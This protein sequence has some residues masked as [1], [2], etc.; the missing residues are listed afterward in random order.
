MNISEK[1]DQ[2]RQL[3][4]EYEKNLCLPTNIPPGDLA[5]IQ[6]YMTMDKVAIESLDRN[7]AI[8]ISIRLAQF[9]L[10]FQRCINYEFA[11]QKWANAEINKAICEE[12]EQKNPYA[13][14]EMK[15]AQIAKENTAVNELRQ[16]AINAEQ[17]VELLNN[18]ANDVKN[19]GYIFSLLYKKDV[20]N[21]YN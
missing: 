14:H 3:I 12:I 5:E 11:K 18:I 10:Y 9:A 17:R 21:E 13:K 6:K 7:S 8:A 20:K 4:D 1:L 19:L 16:I 2:R 15:V